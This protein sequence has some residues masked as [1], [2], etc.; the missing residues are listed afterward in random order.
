MPSHNF[1]EDEEK[2]GRYSVQVLWIVRAAKQTESCPIQQLDSNNASDLYL[3][4]GLFLARP[5]KVP[6]HGA[7]CTLVCNCIPSILTAQELMAPPQQRCWPCHASETEQVP[8]D[9]MTCICRG[10]GAWCAAAWPGSCG[11]PFRCSQS[12]SVALSRMCHRSLRSAGPGSG[13]KVLVRFVE[14]RISCT[15]IAYQCW[16]RGAGVVG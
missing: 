15:Q 8:S 13:F 6:C 3:Q 14:W 1:E 4:S 9:A 10:V 2:V 16:I 11:R 7:A 12:V 5:L